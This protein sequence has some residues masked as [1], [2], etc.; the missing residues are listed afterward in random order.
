MRSNRPVG[1]VDT[2]WLNMDRPNNLMVIDGVMWFEE[3]LD[4]DRVVAVI[5][6][7]LV[8]RYPVFRQRPRETLGGLGRP[9][10]EDDPD[11]D[12]RRHVH[13][14]RLPEP[15]DVG[16]LQ[17]YV[18]AQ[19][20]RSLPR[21]RPLWEAHFIDGYDGGSAVMTRFHHSLAD[22]IALAEVLLSLSDATPTGDLQL[23]PAGGRRRARAGHTVLLH[24]A[25]HLVSVAPRLALPGTVADA[26]TLARQTA[27]VADKLLL[28]S[29][30]ATAFAGR[31]GPAKRAVWCDPRPLDDVKRVAR[32]AG[33]T[34]NDVVVGAVSGAIHD[35]LVAHDGTAVDLTTMV[36]VNL[37]PPGEPLPVELG[38]KFALV[39]LSLPSGVGPPL[40]RLA[41]TK[42]R[43]D[44]IKHSPEAL[45]TFGVSTAIGWTPRQVERLLVNFFSSKAFG[46]TTNVIGPPVPRYLAGSR[47]AGV[48]GWVPG[49][50]NQ[51][52]GV[53][54]FTYDGT[55][56]VGF[57]ADADVVPH[58]ERLVAAFDEEM[59][60]L[61]RMVRAA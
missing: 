31:P 12:V 15:G 40:A 51:T 16:A 52:L 59:D 7:R 45:I 55:V 22:G 34:V 21:D 24:D 32:L 36:P 54:I 57:K 61:L 5:E 49:S 35:Y 19:I 27:H 20:S 1:A 26:V 44:A 13:H 39:L 46:V 6:E 14:T 47:I 53:C 30:P 3:Q 18:D 8:A 10:W 42:L 38:N 58:P 37:R 25:A 60:T 4:W 33:A 41:E 29:N 28:R 56:R 48:L 11:L 50:G 2:M 17:R 43:M 23:R 9:R